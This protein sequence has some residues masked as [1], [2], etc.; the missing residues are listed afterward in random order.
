[1][2][3][4]DIRCFASGKIF[5]RHIPLANFSDPIKCACGA[6]ASRCISAPRFSVDNT[7]YHCPVTGDWISSKKQHEENLK[8]HDCRVLESGESEANRKKREAEEAAFEKKVEDS[9]EKTITEMPSATRE[10]LYNEMVAS[11]ISVDRQ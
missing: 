6:P 11:D 4:Y 9:V 1:V 2:P 5:E 7:G 10:K 3:L 8:K